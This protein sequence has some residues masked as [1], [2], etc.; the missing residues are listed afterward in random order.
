MSV[1]FKKEWKDIISNTENRLKMK[2]KN[3]AHTQKYLADA[4]NQDSEE[5]HN[6]IQKNKEKSRGKKHKEIKNQVSLH[7]PEFVRIE[8]PIKEKAIRLLNHVHDVSLVHKESIPQLAKS[9]EKQLSTT[10]KSGKRNRLASVKLLNSGYHEKLEEK[11]SGNKVSS[12]PMSSG[13]SSDQFRDNF[14]KTWQIRG[15]KENSIS[16]QSKSNFVHEAPPPKSEEE[17]DTEYFDE[18]E[19]INV[20]LDPVPDKN[21][22][23]SSIS[24]NPLESQ[25]T[26]KQKKRVG[27]W[28]VVPEKV[29]KSKYN[30][31]R[32][33]RSTKLFTQFHPRK[34]ISEKVKENFNK[35]IH[36]RRNYRDEKG[37]KN[38][39]KSKKRAKTFT[40]HVYETENIGIEHKMLE[41][42]SGKNYQDGEAGEREPGSIQYKDNRDKHEKFINQFIHP[43]DVKKE[44]RF[45][46][47][48]N[49]IHFRTAKY[50]ENK[51]FKNRSNHVY[52]KSKKKG[53][54]KNDND[55]LIKLL[56]KIEEHHGDL[57][58][59]T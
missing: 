40:R 41:K 31:H 49:K 52:A 12:S 28:E 7:F 47:F 15:G 17:S 56:E 30:N 50:K 43:R 34:K 37:S 29:N 42:E 44:E 11:N 18:S 33:E 23:N 6:S 27:K 19:Y 46:K 36:P 20:L 2:G 48:Q 32:N 9:D 10:Q 59:T 35:Q 57:Q 26:Y 13:H 51:E 45:E 53:N 16:N 1:H 14:A 4:Q 54:D 38:Q 58:E 8:I 39:P 55:F 24:D 3:R 25:Q 22:D 5:I 21:N